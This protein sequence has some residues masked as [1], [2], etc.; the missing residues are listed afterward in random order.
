[1]V[2]VNK[3]KVI[4]PK[5]VEILILGE[6]GKSKERISILKD[7]VANSVKSVKSSAG[8][9]MATVKI[10]NPRVGRPLLDEIKR[11]ITF[12]DI[13]ILDISSSKPN[14]MFNT[15]AIYELGFVHGLEHQRKIS[16]KLDTPIC[17][18][19]A[20][21]EKRQA[22]GSQFSNLAGITWADYEQSANINEIERSLHSNIRRLYKR[23][24]N[25]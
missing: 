15:N 10:A 5:K 23:K 12:S 24:N 19:L 25:L 22:V 7:A 18:T 21:K 6:F 4:R 3:K 14:Q 11:T 2:K 13:V 1:M 8:L 9:Q 20:E 17:Y 16:L